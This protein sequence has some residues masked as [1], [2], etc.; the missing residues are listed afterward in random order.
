MSTSKQ[1]LPGRRNHFIWLTVPSLTECSHTQSVSAAPPS[2]DI[3]M[4]FV[5]WRRKPAFQTIAD[6]LFFCQWCLTL[7]L[8]GYSVS[9]GQRYGIIAL[10][11]WVVHTRV[12]T[13]HWVVP[14]QP[15]PHQSLWRQME[16]VGRMWCVCG[17]GSRTRIL[18]HWVRPRHLLTG[19][20]PP[21]G[22]SGKTTPSSDI[23]VRQ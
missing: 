15:R 13:T 11:H 21:R 22:V 4:P 6:I 3:I 20:L 9:D 19:L 17:S 10:A 12:W 5:L 16:G 23:I 2:C 1:P 7:L 18:N 14:V 8:L